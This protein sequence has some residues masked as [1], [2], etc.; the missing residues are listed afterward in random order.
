MISDL[1]NTASEA[2]MNGIY[3]VNHIVL[4]WAISMTT[5]NP[6]IDIGKGSTFRDPLIVY[7]GFEKWFI[8][9]P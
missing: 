3:L 1:T 9:F 6:Q 2:K 4:V 7:S 8:N 5:V